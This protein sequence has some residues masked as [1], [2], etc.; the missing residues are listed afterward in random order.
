MVDS[1]KYVSIRINTPLII[2]IPA[3]LAGKLKP[4]A[5]LKKKK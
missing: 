2:S 4:I 3:T 5:Y 1:F